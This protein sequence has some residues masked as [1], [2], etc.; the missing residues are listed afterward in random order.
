MSDQLS[1]I[2]LTWA[3]EMVDDILDGGHDVDIKTS[4]INVLGVSNGTSIYNAVMKNNP[5][6]APNIRRLEVCILSLLLV[7]AGTDLVGLR[8]DCGRVCQAV[9][10][11]PS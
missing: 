5:T 10:L 9:G 4:F 2:R 7:L 8:C 1:R 11:R 6:F 3:V